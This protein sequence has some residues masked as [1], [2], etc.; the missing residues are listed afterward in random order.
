MQKPPGEAGRGAGR[1]PRCHQRGGCSGAQEGHPRTPTEKL[2]SARHAKGSQ[3]STTSGPPCEAE[4]T[5]EKPRKFQTGK[6]EL[7]ALA[8]IY[9]AFHCA[10]YCKSSRDVYKVHRTVCTVVY[11]GLEHPRNLV[12]KEGP[13]PNPSDTQERAAVHLTRVTLMGDY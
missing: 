4:N 6:L 3:L 5:G 8:A 11:M 9:T 13:A 2:L 12:S 10:R 7:A 1:S